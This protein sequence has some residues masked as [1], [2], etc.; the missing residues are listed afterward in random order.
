MKIS[1]LKHLACPVCLGDLS[2]LIRKRSKERIIE[3]E[4]KCKKH[5]RFSIRN[6]IAYFVLQFQKQGEENRKISKIEIEKEIKKDWLKHFSKEE[7]KALYKEWNWML[8]FIKKDKNS[9]HL[10]FA[11]GTGRFLRNIISKTKGEMIAL[12]FDPFTCQELSYLLKR[13]KKYN[14]V[15][16]VCA[17]ANKMPFKNNV[18]DSVSS[19]H[20]LDEPKIEK[21]IKET[22][23]VLKKRGYFTI[24]GIHYRK[25]SKS[26]LLAKK[27]GI[28]FTTKEAIISLM[29]KLHFRQIKYKTFYKG[30]WKEKG[31]YLPV[32]ND[33][34]SVYGVAAKK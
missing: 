1:I 8:S 11:T 17:D 29:K 10:D 25:G 20:G 12:E 27:N 5:H 15:S 4:L 31:D 23:R 6:S 3:G 7:L 2:L 14:R 26:F 28:R 34:Y 32:F 18:F 33:F 19:W 16:I 24:S 21:A 30:K 13:I 9:L 22:K